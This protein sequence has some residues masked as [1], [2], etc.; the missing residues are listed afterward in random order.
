MVGWGWAGGKGVGR[1]WA[2]HA[3]CRQGNHVQEGRVVDRGR[4][5]GCRVGLTVCPAACSPPRATTSPWPRWGA[6]LGL[7]DVRARRAGGRTSRGAK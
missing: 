6:G 5:P 2:Q 7:S 4:A 3:A 1:G